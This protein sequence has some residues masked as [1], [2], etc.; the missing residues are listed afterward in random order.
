MKHGK[1]IEIN[2]KDKYKYVGEY[3]L[4]KKEGKGLIEYFNGDRYKGEFVNDN[5]HG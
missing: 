1:G 2:Y 3:Q 4:G 5:K